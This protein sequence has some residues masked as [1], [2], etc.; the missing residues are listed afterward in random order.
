MLR[1]CQPT[2]LPSGKPEPSK[3][4]CPPVDVVTHRSSERTSVDVVYTPYCHVS[5]PVRV[6]VS[7]WSR[8]VPVRVQYTVT[9]AGVGVGSLPRSWCSF[10]LVRV[11]VG[12]NISTL[13]IVRVRKH[14]GV[15]LFIYRHIIPAIQPI[16]RWSLL[17]SQRLWGQ[18][19]HKSGLRGRGYHRDGLG[20]RQLNCLHSTCTNVPTLQSFTARPFLHYRRKWKTKCKGSHT[21]KSGR[22]PRGLS[23]LEDTFCVGVFDLQRCRSWGGYLIGDAYLPDFT[24]HLLHFDTMFTKTRYTCNL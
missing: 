2:K 14:I 16:C 8:Q 5:V 15:F 11:P 7:S 17:H 3:A 9:W 6:K 12:V 13:V 22:L 20:I 10:G 18:W 23:E 1:L 21:V 24:V 19:R 4:H